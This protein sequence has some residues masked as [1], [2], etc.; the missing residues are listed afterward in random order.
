MHLKTV[1]C[2]A[3]DHGPRGSCCHYGGKAR[4]RHL[5]TIFYK[6]YLEKEARKQAAAKAEKIEESQT[7]RE[8]PGRKS[9]DPDQKEV[10]FRWRHWL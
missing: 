8:K 5:G 7:G 3:P 6:E 10:L 1:S 9:K 4:F 2:A